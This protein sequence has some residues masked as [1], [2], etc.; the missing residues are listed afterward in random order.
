MP[1]V[2]L[3][4]LPSLLKLYPDSPKPAPGPLGALV[5]ICAYYL[6]VTFFG[7]FL[8]ARLGLGVLNN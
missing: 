4:V 7:I 1:T 5:P 8:A 2:V 3:Q 6:H